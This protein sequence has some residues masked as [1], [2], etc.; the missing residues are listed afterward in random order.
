MSLR[1]GTDIRKVE[2]TGADGVRLVTA[3]G[4][5]LEF[6]QA[7]LTMPAPIAGR[8]CPDLS[9]D[10]KDLLEKVDYQGIVCASLLLKKPLG[11]Y[12]ITNITDSWVP[13][14]AVIEMSAFVDREEI[15]GPHRWSIFRATSQA[16]DPAFSLSDD[17]WKERFL[18]A[19]FRMYPDLSED[20][21]LS[22]RYRGKASSMPCRR[23]GTR[24]GCP[25]NGPP[26][27]VVYI[28]NSAQIVNGTLNVN[29]SL[30]LAT[31]SLQEITGQTAGSPA[32]RKRGTI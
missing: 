6:D 28:V 12:Y 8:I 25:P 23:S 9:E 18:E 13:F 29:E 19:L 2:G 15:P 30:K 24:T 10:E 11:R 16:H 5:E 7:V 22:S 3:A 26:F 20:D 32:P 17:E 31:E 27:P 14:T 4:D 1:T 21:V